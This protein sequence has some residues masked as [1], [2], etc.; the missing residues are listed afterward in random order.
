MKRWMAVL[1]CTAL[2]TG[3]GDTVFAQEPPQVLVEEQPILWTDAAPFLDENGRTLVPLRAVAEGLG[4]T[5]EWDAGNR[6]A[7]FLRETEESEGYY[8]AREQL[9]FS[10]GESRATGCV[11]VCQAGQCH[12]EDLQVV[13]MD[14]AAVIVGDRVYA[15]LRYL[16]EFFGYTVEW[17]EEACAAKVFRQPYRYYYDVYALGETQVTICFTE[18]AL[19]SE[20]NGVEVLSATVN[21]APAEV[22]PLTA[23]ELAAMQ[24]RYGASLFLGFR[25]E[26]PEKVSGEEVLLRWTVRERTAAGQSEPSYALR[27]ANWNPV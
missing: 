20:L 16:A 8:G 18:G 12:L 26:W 1:L 10:V 7:R 24:A 3:I 19:F 5:V 25:M 11:Y 14:T 23:E 2:L 22:I 17:D 15:P 13:E 4:L 6:Q 21:G 27:L 9:T